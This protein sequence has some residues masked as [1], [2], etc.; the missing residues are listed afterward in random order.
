MV[1]R[2]AAGKPFAF[3]GSRRSMDTGFR[4][5]REIT[6]ACLQMRR[7]VD[8]K[9]ATVETTLVAI[10]EAANGDTPR[11]APRAPTSLIL[12]SSRK[13]GSG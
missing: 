7:V 3:W 13:A 12:K 8:T 1:A 2:V 9:R 6:I 11:G 10:E 4:R 5:E